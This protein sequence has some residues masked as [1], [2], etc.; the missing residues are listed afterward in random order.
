MPLTKLLDL[1]KLFPPLGVITPFE[2]AVRILST[3][4]SEI[5]NTVLGTWEMVGSYCWGKLYDN[6]KCVDK[7]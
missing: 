6:G 4:D 3:N 7:L 2:T 5:L 1:S